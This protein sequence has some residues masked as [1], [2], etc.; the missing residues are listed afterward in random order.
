MLQVGSF[1]LFGVIKMP[2]DKFYGRFPKHIDQVNDVAYKEKYIV[3]TVKL[4]KKKLLIL[5]AI[6]NKEK[7]NLALELFLS[8]MRVVL[9]N[10]ILIENMMLTI[11]NLNFCPVQK[12]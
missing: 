3:E 2:V 12:V 7:N 5:K 10:F 8:Q 11:K 9:L 4:M 1:F 6:S